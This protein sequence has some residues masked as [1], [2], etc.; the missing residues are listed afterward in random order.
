MLGAPGEALGGDAPEAAAGGGAAPAAAVKA[1]EWRGCGLRVGV[2]Q[3]RR[4][5]VALNKPRG[6]SLARFTPWTGA[7]ARAHPSSSSN[8]SS[9]RRRPAAPTPARPSLAPAPPPPLSPSALP[10][11]PRHQCVPGSQS[12]ERRCSISCMPPLQGGRRAR[13][14]LAGWL[15]GWLALTSCMHPPPLLCPATAAVSVV[16]RIKDIEDEMA[17]TQKNKATA[18]H[19][20][21]LKMSSWAAQPAAG[22]SAGTKGCRMRAPASAGAWACSAP[23]SH[24]RCCRPLHP[25]SD[26]A[27]QAGQ[28]ATRA[29][30]AVHGRWRR[31]QGRCACTRGGCC[32]CCTVVRARARPLPHPSG[33]QRCAAT[34]LLAPLR[35]ALT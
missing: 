35:R 16:Q 8:S 25:P 11:S 2:H 4:A 9:R 20:G 17:R 34:L 26:A 30:G 27:R 7:P 1:H 15:V 18:G 28:I 6:V 10:R 14:P 24:E 22:W 23:C 32:C 31:R 21:L 19:L 3:Q 33:Q 13:P 29:A 12:W 5:A